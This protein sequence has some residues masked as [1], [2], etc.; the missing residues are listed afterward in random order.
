MGGKQ[1]GEYG[2][3]SFVD[4]N[5]KNHGFLGRLFWEQK[6]D[7]KMGDTPSV[8]YLLHGDPENPESESWGGSFVKR[9][10][11]IGLTIPIPHLLKT[12]AP[13]QKQSTNG[14]KNFWMIGRKGWSG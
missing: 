8:L 10:W 9:T 13:A 2:N 14:E 6:Q 3:I 4:K 7:I 1:S 5:I 11:L 12:T